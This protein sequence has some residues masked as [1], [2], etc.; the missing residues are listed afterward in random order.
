MG[1]YGQ[2]TPRGKVTSRAGSSV[3]MTIKPTA[4]PTASTGPRLLVEFTSA[5]DS[6]SIAAM[7]VA[8]LAMI[9]GPACRSAV[10]I[11]A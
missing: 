9:A 5:A 1:L 8:A 3:S 11:A 10:A 6:V 2:K 7:T 4:T